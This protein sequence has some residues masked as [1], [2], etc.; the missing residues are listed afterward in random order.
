MFG[1][2]ARAQNKEE[3]Q[4]RKVVQDEQTRALQ[5]YYFQPVANL[6]QQRQPMQRFYV[7][8]GAGHDEYYRIG[9]LPDSTQVAY[10][11]GKI[12][13]F[14]GVTPY[15]MP[16]FLDMDYQIDTKSTDPVQQQINQLVRQAQ[17]LYKLSKKHPI[18][19]KF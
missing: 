19:K 9:I 14:Q 13:L 4:Q 16:N 17:E 7:D 18:N 11:H 12:V 5:M 8:N 1:L 2:K 15:G 3:K 10:D 6:V